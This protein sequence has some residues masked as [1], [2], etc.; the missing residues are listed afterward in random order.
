MT[1]EECACC[2]Q[3]SNVVFKCNKC[4]HFVC[5]E[6]LKSMTDGTCSLCSNPL[7]YIRLVLGDE[8]KEDVKDKVKQVLLKLSKELRKKSE[9]LKEFIFI[10]SDSCNKIVEADAKNMKMQFEERLE[11]M[12][13]IR[14]KTVKSKMNL[15]KVKKDLVEVLNVKNESETNN[16]SSLYNY[17]KINFVLKFFI[18]FIKV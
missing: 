3:L 18:C 14:E 17:G 9:N 15:D 11:L 7:N 8:K 10:S 5:E 1:K 4:R 13:T 6:C 12:K 2:Y 16:Q